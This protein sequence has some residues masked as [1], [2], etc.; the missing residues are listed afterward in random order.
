MGKRTVVYRDFKCPDC[1]YFRS[2]TKR[3]SKATGVGH[4]KHMYC[5]ICKKDKNFIQVAGKTIRI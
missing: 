4:L 1:G 5:P 3:A 2:A